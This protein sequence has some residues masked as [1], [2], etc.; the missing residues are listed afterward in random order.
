ML[1]QTEPDA[2]RLR[3]AGAPKVEVCGNLKFD[4]TPAPA[5]SSA[6]TPGGRRSAG[7][8]CWRPARA[9]ARRRRCS[10]AWRAQPAPRPLLLLVP[11][12]PQRFDEVAAL[13][14]QSGLSFARRSAWPGDP[15]PE[16]HA[17]DVWLGDSL[18]E[19]PLY[20]ARP[21]WRCWA[22]ASSRWAART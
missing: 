11:R 1:A 9:R 15:P 2:Q 21:M 6:A 13:I 19:M 22:A 18:G 20:Y 10:T 7:R 17:L 3:V 14:E 5:C 16:A 8:W 12:H 4:V